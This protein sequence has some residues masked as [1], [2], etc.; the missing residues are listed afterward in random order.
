[1]YNRYLTNVSLSYS[2]HEWKDTFVLGESLGSH[3]LLIFWEGQVKEIMF[4]LYSLLQHG[5]SSAQP[6]HVVHGSFTTAAGERE[7]R[8][9]MPEQLFAGVGAGEGDMVSWSQGCESLRSPLLSVDFAL[10]PSS[11]HSLLWTMSCSGP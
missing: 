1:M 2:S 9:P 7:V 11:M 10:L 3:L 5:Y 4:L 6:A 8:G